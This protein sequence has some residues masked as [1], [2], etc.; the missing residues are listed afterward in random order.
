MATVGTY[1]NTIVA[2]SSSSLS[3]TAVAGTATTYVI[4]DLTGTVVSSG[5]MSG[6]SVTIT[7]PGGG[8]PPGWMIALFN[9]AWN[10]GTGFVQDS[11]Q[12]LSMRNGV[13]PLPPVPTVGTSP[14]ASDP[15]NRGMDLYMHAFLAMGPERWEIH[16]AAHPTVFTAGTE[17]GG[18]IAAIQANLTLNAGAAGYTNPTYADPARP[19]PEI[20]TFPN[21]Q[22]TSNGYNAAEPG[23][24]AGF[25]AA[26]VALGP[27]SSYGVTHFQGV[28]E[29]FNNGFTPTGS[30]AEY[31]AFRI[32]VKAGNA[33]ALAMG[34]AEVC[35]GALG[36]DSPFGP[37]MDALT[38]WIANIPAGSL[39]EFDVHDYN[40][41]NGDFVV[42][43]GWFGNVTGFRGALAAAG[44]SSSPPAWTR[45]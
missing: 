11:V 8:W 43:D 14:N 13:A 15:N 41:Y 20:V 30:A 7:A 36:T 5:S 37:K 29:P 16:D 40:A 24:A 27:A 31:N 18:T 3:V 2:G 28:N 35:Y 38:T 17:E 26:V 34:P 33:S 45:A 42:T 39:D 21:N 6:S 22:A 10:G 12:I 25:E 44:Y 1:D 9:G 32:A 19:H 4:Y 23:Y